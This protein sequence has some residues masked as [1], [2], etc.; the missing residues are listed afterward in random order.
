ME[1]DKAKKVAL[2][3][4]EGVDESTLDDIV[5]DLTDSLASLVNNR[6][7]I[8]QVDFM[9][10]QVGPDQMLDYVQKAVVG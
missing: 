9:I 7:F 3:L 4:L 10:K 1:K 8:A 2:A 5:Y 6:G